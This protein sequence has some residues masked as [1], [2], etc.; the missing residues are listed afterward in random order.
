MLSGNYG[1]NLQCPAGYIGTGTCASG[2][3]TDCGTYTSNRL[4]CCKVRVESEQTSCQLKTTGSYGEELTCNDVN[5]RIA[6]VTEYCGSGAGKDC[7]SI[8]AILITN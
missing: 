3:G 1:V 7:A 5:G 8:K 4:K 6:L 2:T